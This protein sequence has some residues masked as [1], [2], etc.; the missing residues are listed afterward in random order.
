MD[1]DI[2]IETT[3][4][5]ATTV[6][7]RCGAVTL[8][9]ADVAVAPVG[10]A[11]SAC[12]SC[13][14][15]LTPHVEA[16]L[17]YLDDLAGWIPQRRNWV[18]A[19]QAPAPIPAG[20]VARPL[21]AGH[22]GGSEPSATPHAA[23]VILGTGVFALVAAAIAFTAYAW[24]FL[25]PIGQLMA[26]VLIGGASMVGGYLAA[27]KV[28]A[29]ATAFSIA[30]VALLVVSCGYLLTS[31]SVG[32]AAGRAFAVAVAAAVGVAVSYRIA[33]R[34]Q[35]AGIAA[36]IAFA[37]TV[38]AAIAAAPALSPGPAPDWQG[39]WVAG[40]FVI[41]GGALLVLDLVA[42]DLPR[43]RAPWPWLAVPGEVVG[44]L[45]AAVAT[46]DQ[47]RRGDLW[48]NSPTFGATVV[49]IA[50]SAGLLVLDRLTRFRWPPVVLGSFLL[51]GSAVLIAG[52][53]VG[54]R[55]SRPWMA[56]S[57][58][59]ICL[60]LLATAWD[61]GARAAPSASAAGT[62]DGSIATPP[63]SARSAC[64]VGA[65]IATRLAVGALGASVALAALPFAERPPFDT[66]CYY[67]CDQPATT[68]WLAAGYPWWRGLVVGVA[69]VALAAAL[70]VALRR[71]RPGTCADLPTV[72]G[73]SVVGFW[74][75]TLVMD[76][77]DFD[78]DSTV[79]RP[80]VMAA[81]LLG[82][83]GLHVLAVITRSPRSAAW[84]GAG[85]A[86]SG[87]AVAWSALGWGDLSAGPE[88]LGI[89]VAVPLVVCGLLLPWSSGRP[90]STWETAAPALAAVLVFPLA[91]MLVDVVARQVDQPPG[92]T[93]LSRSLGLMA[94]GV[95][96]VV[97]GVRRQWAAPL[98]TG[99]V[100]LLVVAVAES[101]DLARLVPQWV[102]LG[103]V[104][105]VLLG[106]GARWESVRRSGSR[107]RTWA[108][109]LR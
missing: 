109:G 47:M 50:A 10:G 8:S 41:W 49:V 45:V 94:V 95:L 60:L 79:V 43:L 27:R 64:L 73:A 19:Q 5:T 93:A 67:P 81:L 22:G 68:A 35:G 62:A 42:A 91:A 103:I 72:L 20:A 29:A 65:A 69:V 82:G 54:H 33:G 90:L 36:A 104:G 76:A 2:G 44:V 38:L 106:V 108:H 85:I 21:D 48:G 28:P 101:L 71:L 92:A 32:V 105:V 74:S 9:S 80:A 107:T 31:Q 1:G 37:L 17:R 100:T 23:H 58:L 4:P 59:L 40:T 26:L 96:L 34:Q 86:S 46:V 57:A 13:G 6:C 97:V 11:P 84:V 66:S 55:S 16:E 30:G 51:T 15:V 102:S 70:S 53:N 78:I 89:V 63:T 56:T 25:G 88:L 83:L 75:M 98:W 39:W 87:A 14:F 18:L 77:A 12:P 61:L 52:T 24:S 7:A 3:G 99:V